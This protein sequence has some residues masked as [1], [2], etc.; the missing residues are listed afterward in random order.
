MSQANF[1]FRAAGGF[2]RGK[3]PEGYAVE[4]TAKKKKSWGRIRL[5]LAKVV[6]PPGPRTAADWARAN[7]ADGLQTPGEVSVSGR[8]ARSRAKMKGKDGGRPI[9]RT[10][11]ALRD[12]TR[13]YLLYLDRQGDGFTA[14]LAAVASGF[15]I[16]DP[17][18]APS[19]EAPPDSAALK[20]G[21]IEKDYYRLKLFKPAGFVN[22]TVD[23][24]ADNGIVLHLRRYDAKKN[25]CDIRIRVWLK[26][27]VKQPL[28]AKARARMD[29]FRGKYKNA[30]IP[31]KPS[32]A[33][34]RS[35]KSALKLKLV[36][37]QAKTGI[38]ITE[39]WRFVEHE[40]DRVYEIQMIIAGEA[41]RTWK[42]DI[43]AFWKRLVIENR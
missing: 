5:R 24:D 42:K 8:G 6:P 27:L 13:I 10:L 11:V 15:T 28:E 40:N 16:L 23:P 37:Q 34:W 12:G 26:K 31:K 17:K 3:A 41:A 22:L 1:L 38:V 19:E 2:E 35:A 9:E 29:R 30:K 18:G 20:P 33:R 39:E 32:R 43:R 7:V 36:G 4:L 14:A 25:L 21:T